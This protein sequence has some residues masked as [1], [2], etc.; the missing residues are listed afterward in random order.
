M[1]RPRY[2]WWSYMKAISRKYTARRKYTEV[3]GRELSGTAKKEQDAVSEAVKATL[4]LPNGEDRIHVVNLV[5]FQG[6]HRIPGAA[7]E[8]HCSERT[9]QR[10]HSDFIKEVAKNY[11]LLD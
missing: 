3:T 8:T 5:L 10:W 4:A 1:S 2:D 6:T 7:I 11:G 9:A